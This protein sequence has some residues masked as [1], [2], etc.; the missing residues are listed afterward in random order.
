MRWMLRA[1]T[2]LVSSERE[3]G[4]LG[5]LVPV[6]DRRRP[7][8]PRQ[9]EFIPPYDAY[10]FFLGLSRRDL[11]G[12]N[13][14]DMR[15]RAWGGEDRDL[16][17][18]LRR[19][20]LRCGWPGPAATV[21]HLWHTPRKGSMPSNAALRLETQSSSRFV[22]LEGLHELSVELGAPARGGSALG[23]SP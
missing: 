10:G 12:V 5:V 23:S 7:W 6:R 21:L 4:R 19:T 14:F 15:Y 9:R 2:E 22:A 20:G 16:V 3:A 8:R 18:R 1:P 13:G 17:W 11:E